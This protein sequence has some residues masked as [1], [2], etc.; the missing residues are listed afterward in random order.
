MVDGHGGSE[1]AGKGPQPYEHPA[2][3]PERG[4][5]STRWVEFKR[6]IDLI[7]NDGFTK[8]VVLGSSVVVVGTVIGSRI[9]GWS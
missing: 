2:L 1:Q 4:Y 3:E 7:W 5:W 6:L 9:F 8:P